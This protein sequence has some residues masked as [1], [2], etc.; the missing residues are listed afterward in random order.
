MFRRNLLHAFSSP[1]LSRRM[2]Q[3]PP[4]PCYF[5]DCMAPYPKILVFLVQLIICVMWGE[6][7]VRARKCLV[8]NRISLCFVQSP[9]RAHIDLHWCTATLYDVLQM[10]CHSVYSFVFGK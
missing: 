10:V 7:V 4:K 1:P 2:L 5:S 3:V 8:R 9:K 6:L